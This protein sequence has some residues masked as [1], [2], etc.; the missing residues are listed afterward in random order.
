[1]AT[2]NKFQV[3]VEYLADGILDLFGAP[4]GDVLKV[5]LTNTLPNAADTHVDTVLSPDVVEATSNAV[6]IAAGNGYVEGG[7]VLANVARS[8]AGGTFTL[9]ADEFVWTAA[10]GTIGPFQY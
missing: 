3:F 7:G 2:Y 10:G 8:R 6:E 1:M 5:G 4:P 9:G